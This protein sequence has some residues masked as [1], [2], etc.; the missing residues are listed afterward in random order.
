MA[1]Q[2]VP[3][4]QIIDMK[5]T[6]KFAGIIAQIGNEVKSL[7]V[8]DELFVPKA[9]KTIY[10]APQPYFVPATEM[11]TRREVTTHHKQIV[12]YAMQRL[13]L[14]EFVR[15]IS[16]TADSVDQGITDVKVLEA[17]TFSPLNWGKQ[18]LIMHYEQPQVH[19]LLRRLLTMAQLPSQRKTY[20]RDKMLTGEAKQEYLNYMDMIGHVIRE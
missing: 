19:A 5:E 4:N 11:M 15:F 17:A 3:S 18:S 6:D 7:G 2:P 12:G 9:F 13:S 20:I 14:E 1:A 10:E 8:P 16:V